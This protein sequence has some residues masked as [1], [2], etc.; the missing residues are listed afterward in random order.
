V[1]GSSVDG[2]SVDGSSV[3]GSFVWMRSEF[4]KLCGTSGCSA[5]V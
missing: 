4:G 5:D 1:D 3:D 2:S